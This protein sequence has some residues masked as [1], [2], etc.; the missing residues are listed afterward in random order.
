[1]ECRTAANLKLCVSF[2]FGL[3]LVRKLLVPSAAITQ[4]SG[5]FPFS[6]LHHWRRPRRM[7][8]QP[9]LAKKF[10]LKPGPEPGSRVG[11]NLRPDPEP[12]LSPARVGPGSGLKA[13][14]KPGLGLQAR[15]GT[16]LLADC[17]AQTHEHVRLR[18]GDGVVQNHFLAVAFGLRLAQN[19][20]NVAIVSGPGQTFALKE[21]NFSTARAN[22]SG[23]TECIH[24]Q[25]NV[26]FWWFVNNQEPLLKSIF[27]STNLYVHCLWL[28]GN[29]YWIRDH[30]FLFGLGN[31]ISSAQT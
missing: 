24:D 10:W 31:S 23:Q 15:P 3:S 25:D 13:R 21:D 20:G 27:S 6:R 18:P 11:Q 8:A 14:P 26:L 30:G 19:V 2:A 12:Y 29:S 16:S 1:M 4:R 22:D 17:I 28:Q 5:C 7:H 9:K